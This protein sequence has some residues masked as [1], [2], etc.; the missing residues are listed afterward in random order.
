M[1]TRIFNAALHREH[2]LTVLTAQTPFFKIFKWTSFFFVVDWNTFFTGFLHVVNFVQWPI[3][4]ARCSTRR[5]KCWA[6]KSLTYIKLYYSALCFNWTTFWFLIFATV[7]IST[8]AELF[9]MVNSRFI[10]TKTVHISIALVIFLKILQNKMYFIFGAKIQIDIFRPSSEEV[11]RCFRKMNG[12]DEWR[13]VWWIFGHIS[14]HVLH[15]NVN[16]NDAQAHSLLS[17]LFF[18]P[19][20][21]ML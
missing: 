13:N 10:F 5:T 12:F 2:L 17:Q 3:C 14:L 15:I 16:W 9:L 21:G 4:D 18:W 20:P 8:E 1:T 11:R 6:G 19:P 7:S